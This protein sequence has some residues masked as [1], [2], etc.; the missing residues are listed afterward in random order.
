MDKVFR[1]YS[2]PLM[3]MIRKKAI[4]LLI[5]LTPQITEG[6]VNR[7]ENI[8]CFLL[9]TSCSWWNLDVCLTIAETT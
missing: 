5:K 9:A 3:F 8:N 4:H 6:R 2:S 1:F 7:D